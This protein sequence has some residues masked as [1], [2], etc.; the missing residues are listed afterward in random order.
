MGLAEDVQALERR[1][2]QLEE[3]VALLVRH[4]PALRPE[5]PSELEALRAVGDRVL[6]RW[7]T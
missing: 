1:C 6:A 4:A 5:R 3:L 7:D 2:N